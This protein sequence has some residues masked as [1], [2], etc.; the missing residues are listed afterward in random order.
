MATEG[1]AI[2]NEAAAAQADTIEFRNAPDGKPDRLVAQAA[3]GAEGEPQL[4]DPA[5]GAPVK[6]AETAP[7]TPPMPAT[8]TADAS[9]VVHL[10]AGASIEKIKVVGSDIVLEQP[11]GSTITIHNA[12]LKVPTFVI[13]DAE[14]PRET[15]VAVLGENGINVAAGPDGSISVVSNQSS[16][17]GFSDANGDIGQAGPVIDLLPPTSL[18]FPA[19]EATELLPFTLDANENPSIIPDGGSSDPS[20]IFV[21]DREVDE[22]G[23]ASGSRAGDGSASVNGVFTISD[24]DGLGDVAS[25][26]INGQTFA[27]GGLAGQ[28]VTGLFGVLTI[29]AYD[30]VTGVAQYTYELTSPVTGSGPGTNVEQDRDTFNL[31]VT[32][33]DGATGTAALRIDVVDDVPVIGIT[34]PVSS[35]VVEGQTLSGN[36]TLAAGADGVGT[37]NVTVGNTTQTLTLAAGQK[38]V[39]ALAEGTLTVNADKSWS[40]AAANNLN[41]AGGVNVSF[42]L[43]A[44]DADGDTTSDSQTITVVDGDGPKVDPLAASA[45]LTLDDQNLADGSTP[46]GGA[47]TS[48]GT[49]GFV[50]GSD[51]IATIAF[52]NDVSGLSGTLTWDRVSDTQI[53]GRAG[54]VAIVTLDLVRSGDSATV[55]ATLNDNY[56]SHP[57]INADDLANLGSVKVIASDTD[58]DKA[59][60]TVTVSVSDDVPVIDVSKIA[61]PAAATVDETVL[62]TD[63]SFTVASVFQAGFS[64]YGADGAGSVSYGLQLS[65]NNV[66]SGLFAHGANGAKGAEILLSQS[67]NVITGAVNGTTYFTITLANG[68]VT[69]DQLK[70]IWHGNTGSH[71]EPLSLNIAGGTLQLVATVTDA[72]G[73]TAS[74][75]VNLGG[76]S[77][78]TF[79]DDGPSID[80]SKIAA[81]AAATVDETVLGTDASFTVASVFQAGFSAYGAD[82]AGSVSYGLQLSGNN[83][84]SGLFA[85]GANG[86][87]GAEILLSQSGNVITG[88]V[89]GTT[90]FTI[91]LA[92]GQVTLDQL[93]A[94]WHGN[95]GSHDEPLS[96]NIAGGTLQLVATVTDADGDT[97]SHSV[98]LGGGSTF[99]FK[100][101][102]PSIDVDDLSVYRTPG[103][104]V[105]EYEFHVGADAATFDTSFPAGALVW[106][107]K[108]TGYDFGLKAGTTSTYAATY[109]DGGTAKTYFELTIKNDGTYEFNL[110]SPAPSIVVNTESLL[111]GLSKTSSDVMSYTFPKSNFGGAF[112][113]VATG[114]NN[115]VQEKLSISSSELG[116]GDGVIHNTNTKNEVLRLD[117]QQQP[118]HDNATISSLTLGL[119]STGSLAAGDHLLLMV[120]YTDGTSVDVPRDYNGSGAVTFSIDTSKTVDYVEFDIVSSNVNAKITGVSLGYTTTVN[121]A[122]SQL[123]FELGGRDADHDTATASFTV[124]VMAGTAGNDVISTGAAADQ[125]SGGAGNDTLFSGEGADYLF[126]GDG[127]DML[128]GGT[129]LDHVTGGAGRDTFVMDPDSLQLSIDDVITDYNHNEGDTVD[130]SALLG[131]LPSTTIMQDNYVRVEDAGGGN[132]NLQVDTDGSAGN[133]SGWHTVAVLEDFQAST[134]VVKILFNNTNGTKT[135]QDIH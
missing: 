10:P 18:Q 63:A 93:K 23:L 91:T 45:A 71:D 7:Q 118:G 14:I 48:S 129:G 62:G 114:Y 17:G 68:Q 90:Y 86:A 97:A 121:P 32:D 116:V 8:V 41:N 125:I 80:V 61:A 113:L 27:I 5:T 64:A 105:G 128:Y 42:S 98:N 65:G 22:A 89:N 29:T 52:S 92:N 40:F 115:G 24:P 59:E 85:H 106:T 12:A 101:D 39:F 21:S 51:A 57:G 30:P 95:T 34:D 107:N 130:L 103:V 109:Q 73:D 131:N 102:G 46:A 75:S 35:N 49:I 69:L 99:T 66:G 84:G 79:K 2:S 31:T 94:I 3:T 120:K 15:L 87:K 124:D 50:A 111:A 44:A 117:V 77:T 60:G 100:D 134:D 6:G 112:E 16:G 123:A 1:T 58:G 37:V 9:N 26:T 78:F 33:A 82:G 25:L 11:D 104:T 67:G 108:P 74:H 13:G 70:A 28:S 126:G 47:E 133:G 127:D 20:G 119:A 132:A 19:L 55:T 56:A 122:D 43:S 135:D 38:V 53:V 36:W 54:G 83:V 96:L 110:V 72:D 4:V 76:G 81:P 88:A